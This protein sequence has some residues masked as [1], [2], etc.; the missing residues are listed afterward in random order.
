MT[1]VTGLEGW[2]EW[3]KLSCTMVALVRKVTCL[4][5][6]GSISFFTLVGGMVSRRLGFI[7]FWL[8]F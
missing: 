7:K 3:E 2:S 6:L 1:A 5:V 8:R 4:L